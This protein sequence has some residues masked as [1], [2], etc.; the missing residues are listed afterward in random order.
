[1]ESPKTS[2]FESLLSSADRWSSADAQRWE[3]WRASLS[4]RERSEALLPLQAL[5]AG[6]VAYRDL[7][8]HADPSPSAGFRHRLQA[9]QAGYDW[10]L[11]LIAALP[12][13]SL[14]PLGALGSK[15]PP[16]DPDAS[17]RSLE[18]S[19]HDAQTVTARLLELPAVDEVAFS[20]S[21]D[22]F[23]REIERNAFFWPAA[24]LE[25]S[26]VA[27]LLP[28]DALKKDLEHCKSE[29]AVMVAFLALLRAH[30]FLGISCRQAGET[31][32]NERARIV[33]AGVR[34]ELDALRLFLSLQGL[35][36]LSLGLQRLDLERDV[37]A[38][39]AR[40]KALAKE[41][42]SDRISTEAVRESERPPKDLHQDVWAFQFILRAFIAKAHTMLAVDAASEAPVSFEFAAEFLQHFQAFGPRLVRGTDYD[43]GR[44]L[45]AAVS[46]LH[47]RR[48]IE[49]D[50]V[51]CAAGE[52]ERF[53][54]HLQA[55]LNEAE[56]SSD[57]LFDKKKAASE[58][59][60]YLAEARRKSTGDRAAAAAFGLADPTPR[61][62]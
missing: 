6:L 27:E 18:R 45:I 36:E 39:R 5:L 34:R 32:G 7:E 10:A 42:R 59:R 62:S 20:A 38:A 8:N 56:S 13:S 2:A 22:L 52:C 16:A 26:N 17:L 49:R 54:D 61:L 23:L 50:D 53:A 29:A 37:E 55:A 1:M 28:S 57:L 44:P 3:R 43:R 47:R 24:P 14:R 58:L 15:P 31:S 12:K 60:E 35:G 25:F 30:R 40:I 33:T 51:E 41:L 9:V 4:E 48:G 46:A 19:L 21:M 11:G